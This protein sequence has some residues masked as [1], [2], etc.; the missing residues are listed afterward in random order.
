MGGG[1]VSARPSP[2]RKKVVGFP[3]PG[4]GARPNQIW[5]MGAQRQLAL[6]YATPRDRHQ[7]QDNQ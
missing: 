2:Q 7:H 3:R 1:V 4:L 5:R 6:R